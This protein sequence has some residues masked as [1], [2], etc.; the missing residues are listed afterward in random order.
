MST[1]RAPPGRGAPA[2]ASRHTP[3]SAWKGDPLTT[4]ASAPS[5]PARNPSTRLPGLAPLPQPDP[6]M[7]VRKKLTLALAIALA[8]AIAVGIGWWMTR[9]EERPPCCTAGESIDDPTA[10]LAYEL[11]A[12]WSPIDSRQLTGSA[13]SGA[14]TGEWMGLGAMVLAYADT[15]PSADLRSWTEGFAASASDLTYPVPDEREILL[16]QPT[17]VSGLEA[18]EVAWVVHDAGQES[19]Y[20][21]V[22]VVRSADGESS[23]ALFGMALPD[24]EALREEVDW[25]VENAALR[26]DG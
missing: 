19:M 15:A 13:S 14:Y 25:I 6:P 4:A 18:Y 5:N 17:S 9:P 1:S 16:S 3:L 20:G 2:I 8:A 10:G 24:E 11:P 23:S 12:D 7:T 22:L 21:H 26:G